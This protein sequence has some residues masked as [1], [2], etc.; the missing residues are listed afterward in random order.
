MSPALATRPA[1]RA[2]GRR[3]SIRSER[4]STI[5]LIS[6]YAALAAAL[7]VVVSA[8]TSLAL[9]RKRLL[10]VADG[11]ALA[12]AEAW[13]FADAPP[14]GRVPVRFDQAAV[15]AAVDEYLTAAD[16]ASGFHAFAVRQ[17]TS[18]GERG[19]TVTLAATWQG[20][21]SAGLIPVAVPIE[22]TA[23]ARSVIR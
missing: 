14:T 19:V 2:T 4:G 9:E 10:T 16:A 11:A 8:A 23:T 20:G 22:V 15:R 12:A 6:A 5:P 7:I 1:A 21:G 18:D 13:S 17:V 3:R